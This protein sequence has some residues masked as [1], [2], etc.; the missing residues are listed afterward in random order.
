MLV[1]SHFPG[2]ERMTVHVVSTLRIG[3]GFVPI[4]DCDKLDADDLYIEGAIEWTVRGNPVLPR[5]HWDLVDQLWAYLV[6]GLHAVVTGESCFETYFPDQPLPLAIR[7][8]YDDVTVVVGDREHAMSVR[9]L[10]ALIPP[11]RAFFRELERLA[12]RSLDAW[13]HQQQRLDQ[14]EALARTRGWI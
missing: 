12:P 10:F 7:R 8:K 14:I 4:E 2:T 11:G 13:Q 6:S 9:E 3:S 5:E 1:R